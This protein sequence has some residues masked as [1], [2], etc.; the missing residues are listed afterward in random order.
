LIPIRFGAK[1]VEID[2]AKMLGRT[3]G[4]VR[5]FSEKGS[6]ADDITKIKFPGCSFSA[7]VTLDNNF[8]VEIHVEG[9][10]VLN[11]DSIQVREKVLA[12]HVKV[13]GR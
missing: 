5:D 9:D 1:S 11:G 3:P 13:T 2:S 7:K 12:D 10:H 4:K 8:L 6:P